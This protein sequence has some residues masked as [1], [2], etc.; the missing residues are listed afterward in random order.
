M[1]QVADYYTKYT[2]TAT[3]RDQLVQGLFADGTN[4]PDNSTF[5]AWTVMNT[6]DTYYGGSTY[7]DLTVDGLLYNY[8]VSRKTSL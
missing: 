2:L 7:S 4:T 3:Y 5:G 6:K 8:I 1:E